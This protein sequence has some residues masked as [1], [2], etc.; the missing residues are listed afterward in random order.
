MRILGGGGGGRRRETEEVGD[1]G[2]DVIISEFVTHVVFEGGFRG[3]SSMILINKINLLCV[4][5][6][7]RDF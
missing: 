6:V 4:R 7:S 5:A 3:G 2:G 1:G